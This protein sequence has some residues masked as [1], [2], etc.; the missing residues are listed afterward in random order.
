[1]FDHK[2]HAEDSASRYWDRQPTDDPHTLNGFAGTWNFSDHRLIP[3]PIANY[4]LE[5]FHK[6]DRLSRVPL[7]DLNNEINNIW[8][9]PGSM[10]KVIRLTGSLRAAR[11]ETTETS[12][13][14]LKGYNTPTI[15]SELVNSEED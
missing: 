5:V 13:D 7:E 10:G 14:P 12:K 9:G 11:L 8:E 6:Y 15:E 2:L 4:L 1:M 3:E